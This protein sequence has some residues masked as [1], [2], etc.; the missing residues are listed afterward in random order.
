MQ[1]PP[2]PR[3]GFGL[4]FGLT[5]GLALLAASAPLGCE[6]D[7]TAPGAS[8]P[9]PKAPAPSDP[10]TGGGAALTK[11]QY[12]ATAV[13]ADG[14]KLRMTVFVP[15][16]PANAPVP[17]AVH[18]HG[19]GLSR[20]TSLEA[21]KDP[22]GAL[23]YNAPEEAARKLRDRGYFV[24]SFDE[25][26]F[27][28]LG[29][30]SRLMSPD[31]EGRDLQAIL[32]WAELHL[33]P[34]LARRSGTPTVTTLGLS[35]GGGYQLVGAA[36]DRRVTTIVP[37]MTWN[38]LR[39]S[40]NP[41]GIPKTDWLN[42]LI[43][44][45]VAGTGFQLDPVLYRATAQ[46]ALGTIDD[47]TLAYVGQRG[48]SAFCTAGKAPKVNAFLVQGY[49]DSLFNMNEAVANADCLRAAGGDVRLLVQRYGHL[50]PVLQ[51]SPKPRIAFAVET[52]VHCD[53]Q[54]FSV[55]DAMVSFVEEKIR[56][57]PPTI[58]IPSLCF[59]QDETR[60][61][62]RTTVP[63]G[64]TV[65]PV[66]A[67]RVTNIPLAEKLVQVL[68]DLSAKE[69]G[70]LL[71]PL[72]SR[73]VYL[74][75]DV[76]FNLGDPNKLS[77]D[78]IYDTLALLPPELVDKLY[79]AARWVPLHTAVVGEDL[80]GLPTHDLQITGSDTL[81]APIAFYGLAIQW[82]GANTR[83]VLGEQVTPL[84]GLGTK[85]GQLAGVSARLEPG[86]VVGL[87][88]YGY[89]PQYLSNVTLNPVPFTVAGSI[90]LPLRGTP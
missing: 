66:P 16:A 58:A 32:D 65:A 48:L 55:T 21:P 31:F 5:F 81:G 73:S 84:R 38:D 14:T 26:G 54:F 53:N 63:I 10:L 11:G 71:A 24:V 59:T 89:H 33:S 23:T 28:E 44:A 52:Q 77:S 90:A 88:V 45:G 6:P 69:V 62:T 34:H 43:A 42:L 87:V 35:Y 3:H 39:Y 83:Q 76:V 4:G 36:L 70:E 13:S 82:R 57:L 56:Q 51:Q 40:L 20:L 74:V 22:I 18:S 17:L 29:G 12:D 49:A 50:L 46:A 86:D 72:G 60:G 61:V 8:A 37:T 15:D 9:A 79:A 19:W 30:E 64:G 27:G 1:F 67:T 75:K 25:R 41:N 68:G 47:P 7:G 2:R 78:L 80:V 85:R